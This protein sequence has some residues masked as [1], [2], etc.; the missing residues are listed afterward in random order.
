M[1]SATIGKFQFRLIVIGSFLTLTLNKVE[2]KE[3]TAAIPK[4]ITVYA[5]C[6][7]PY[8]LLEKNNITTLDKPKQTKVVAV[9]IN[10]FKFA[11]LSLFLA[12]IKQKATDIKAKPTIVKIVHCSLK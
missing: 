7:A 2:I 3:K 9:K 5:L 4:I 6:Q 11:F 1:I 12:G 10:H 8:S